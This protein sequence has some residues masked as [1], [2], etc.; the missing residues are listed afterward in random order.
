MI[1]VHNGVKSFLKEHSCFRPSVFSEIFIHSFIPYSIRIEQISKSGF[2]SENV[3][4]FSHIQTNIPKHY[5]GNDKME[6]LNFF[7]F[8][9][10]VNL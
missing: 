3:A 5:L 8:T 9:D 1:R 7:T 6:I 4:G 10:F 2:M